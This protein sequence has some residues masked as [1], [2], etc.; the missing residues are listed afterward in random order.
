MTFDELIKICKPLDVYG[1]RPDRFNE[2]TQDSRQVRPGSVFIAVR[3]TQVDGHMFIEN[4]ISKGASVIICEDAYYT[5]HKDVSVLEVEDTRKLVGPLAQA[6]EGNP[7]EQLILI[8]VTGTNGKT[9]VVTLVYQA[10]EKLGARPSLLGTVDKR[11]HDEILES[12][13]TTSDPIELARDMRKMV[14]ADSSHLVMEVSSHALDQ[15]RVAGLDFEIAGFTNLSHDHLDYHDTV[16][17]YAEAKKKLF[18][19]LDEDA[20]TIVNGDDTYGEFMIKD[21]RAETTRFGFRTEADVMCSVV[22]S[23]PDGLMVNIDG[24]N[25]ASPLVG[26]YNA[27][28]VALAFLIC[29]AL[30]YNN[31]MIAEALKTAKGASGRLE[32]VPAEGGPLVFVDYAHTPDALENVLATLKELKE[33]GETLHV[34]FGC[35]GNR[36]K[37]KRPEMARISETL[38]D[39]ITVTSDNPRNEDPEAIIDDIMEGFETPDA[40]ARITDRRKAIEEAMGQADEKTIILIAGK[41]HETYQE[42]GGERYDFDDRKIAREALENRNKNQ[43]PEAN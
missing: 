33:E 29:R 18:D 20:S 36:D 38:A 8:G 23:R 42:I 21:C 10:L 13:L 32:R 27:Y 28:N 39:R 17:R 16:D 37:N 43:N 22:S 30:G 15:Q 11:I 34:I 40:V 35:G 41:G 7:A 25:V 6:F 14:E 31:E 24:I 3:G 5:E 12:L 2:L 1:S 26:H 9:T 4:A 19:N